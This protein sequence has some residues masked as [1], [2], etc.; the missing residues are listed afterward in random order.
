MPI[1][2]E[3]R[4][5]RHPQGTAFAEA[6]ELCEAPVTEPGDG[7]VMVRNRWLSLDAGT[8]MWMTPRTDGYQ[9]PLPLG[10]VVPGLVLG[11]VEASRHPGFRE[12]DWVR[13]FGQWADRSIVTPET[14]GLMAVDPAVPDVR[15]HLGALGMNGWTAYVGV[16]EVGR[17]REGETVLVSAAAGATGLLALQ[18]ARLLGCRTIGIAGG[19][20]KCRYLVETMGADA[21]IDRREAD[22]ADRLA[23]LGGIDVYFDNVGGPL[24]DAVLPA[25]AL[26]GRIAVCG[27]VATYDGG[28]GPAVTRFDQI[29]MNRLQVTGFFCPDFFDRGAELTAMLRGWAE[30]GRLALPF[31]ETIGLEHV[32]EAYA[33]LFTGAN[34]GK[35]IVRLDS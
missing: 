24:L 12:G 21:A 2:R 11:E 31:D 27:L 10:C 34:I 13:G 19:E 9:P 22:V 5:Q 28:P 14:S 1:N 15:Q 16:A 25:M 3:W 32:L 30:E 26:H 17:A 29:L 18:I 6:I 7:E 8:R 35:V 23:S 20:A 33:R 4:L